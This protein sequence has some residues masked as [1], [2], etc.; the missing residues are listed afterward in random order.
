MRCAIRCLSLV[1]ATSTAAWAAEQGGSSSPSTREIESGNV[2][3]VHAQI[4]RLLQLQDAAAAGS[5]EAI[6]QQKKLLVTIGPLLSATPDGELPKLS[7]QAVA[8][9]LSG[10]NPGSVDRFRSAD[11]VP[12]H[13]R[14]LLDASA[15]FMSGDREGASKAFAKIDPLPLPARIAGRVALAQS[16]LAD[17]QARQKRL[18]DAVSAM[19]G[20]LVEESSLRRSALAYAAA[21]DERNFWKRTDRFARR[22]SASIYA[23]AFWRDITGAIVAW[24]STESPPSLPHLD[25]TL[26]NLPVAQRRVLYLYLAHGAAK[27]GL[28]KLTDEAGRRLTRLAAEGS[29]E[30][31]LGRFYSALFQIVSAQ[32]EDAL[33][34]LKS[35]D[36]SLLQPDEQA[37]LDAAVRLGSQIEDPPIS[38]GPPLDD[39]KPELSAQESRGVDLLAGSYKLLVDSK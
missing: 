10:G 4:D 16:L 20:T 19:P 31:Q 17:D 37:L 36:R 35:I 28:S 5:I 32:D 26:A 7:G 34:R 6:D 9:V 22:F 18:A 12:L 13:D 11:S 38:A 21:R 33:L 23:S 2:V 24:Y 3:Q 39:A 14:K 8:Y 30:E 1:L 27:A 29:N 25:A 15:L